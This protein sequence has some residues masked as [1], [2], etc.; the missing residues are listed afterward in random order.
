MLSLFS[1]THAVNALETLVETWQEYRQLIFRKSMYIYFLLQID[2]MG[3]HIWWQNR[4][5]EPTEIH[6]EESL[7]Q[8]AVVFGN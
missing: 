3:T 1:H 8:S 5:D 6:E 4:T 2:C 7:K